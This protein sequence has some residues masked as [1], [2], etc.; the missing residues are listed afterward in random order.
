MATAQKTAQK[1]VQ[2]SSDA[3][4]LSDREIV[5]VARE[6][7]AEIGVDG[8]TMRLLSE[9]LGVALGATYHHIPTK[10]DLLMMVGK[11]LHDEVTFPSL[12]G[13]WADQIRALML[14][15]AD[16]VGRYPGMGNYILAHPESLLPSALNRVS[17]GILQDAGFSD[18]GMRAVLGAL[19]FYVGG[20]VIGRSSSGLQA[21]LEGENAEALFKEGLDVLLDGARVR[22]DRERGSRRG[23][24]RG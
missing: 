4:G 21:A 2:K 10:H 17:V 16:I 20:T 19:F 22:L 6:I 3:A 8:L 5:R 11:D 12:K 1:T 9:R 24:R 23:R 14:D 15:V 13:D 18:E 7:I